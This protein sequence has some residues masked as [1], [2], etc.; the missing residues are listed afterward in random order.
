[1][2]G[3][4]RQELAVLRG[5]MRLDAVSPAV[6]D[7]LAIA[8]WDTGV[9]GAGR[10]G[11]ISLQLSSWQMRASYATAGQYQMSSSGADEALRCR[12]HGRPRRLGEAALGP[13]EAAVVTFPLSAF[14]LGLGAIGG[15]WDECRPRLGELLAVGGCVATFPTDGARMAD[16]LVGD[17]PAAPT[18][19]L[20]S[21]LSCEGG[22]RT[23]V[24]FATQPDAS[25][26]P[27]SE[28]AAV[29]LD[30]A[31]GGAAGLVIA[32]ETAG[33][34]GARMLRSP[35]TA[36]PAFEV[37][38]VRDWISF[39]PERTFAMTTALIAGVVA[40][41]P[42]GPLAEHLLPLEI[43]GQFFGHFHAA[44]FSYHPLPQR[45]VELAALARGLFAN[46]ELLDV[47]HLVWDDRGEAGVAESAFARG[48]GW[49]SPITQVD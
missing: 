26:V 7:A 47:L 49:I 20:A 10:P 45:T 6:R 41:A 43:T 37:P 13:D 23:L 29:C 1:V 48:V 17:G 15:E 27:L 24:R 44:V 19:V 39:A 5:G 3:R 2:L 30:A 38:A 33:L 35:G 9:D 40:R 16:Y 25:A 22:F 46:H 21:G 32:G 12:L 42:E 31:G 36:A 34:C 14:G 18:A 28:L 11:P 4:W 8:G